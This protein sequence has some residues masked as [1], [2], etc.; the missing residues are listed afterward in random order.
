MEVIAG[1][2]YCDSDLRYQCCLCYALGCP[3]ALPVMWHEEDPWN[4]S[5]LQRVH[6]FN[7]VSLFSCNA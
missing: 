7:L 2:L 4:C 1:S 5:V 3:A 6:L